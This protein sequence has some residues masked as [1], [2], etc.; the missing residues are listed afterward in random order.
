[1]D[2]NRSIHEDFRKILCADDGAEF[3][4]MEA[5][6]FETP[7]AARQLRYEIDSAYQGQEGLILVEKACAEGRPYALAFVDVRMPPGWDGVET[8][9]KI[10][11]VSPD[12]QNRPLYCVFG[13]YSWDEVLFEAGPFGPPGHFEKTVRRR[14]G[15]SNWQRP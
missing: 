14:G 13:L 12:T 8:T 7:M 2:D 6:L 10:W 1:V 11:K 15:C 9:S 4:G 5:A 3:E